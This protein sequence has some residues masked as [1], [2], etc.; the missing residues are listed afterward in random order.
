M[1]GLKWQCITAPSLG[2]PKNWRQWSNNRSYNW[3]THHVYMFYFL[4]RVDLTIVLSCTLLRPPLSILAP[5]TIFDP[6]T[7]K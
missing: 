3:D 5:I 1:Y 2:Y 4:L 7:T 6:E